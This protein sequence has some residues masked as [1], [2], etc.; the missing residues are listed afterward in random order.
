VLPALLE[1]TKPVAVPPLLEAPEAVVDEVA[2]SPELVIPVPLPDAP[3]LAPALL[4]A[5]A[6]AP[7][8]PLLIVGPGTQPAARIVMAMPT[9][10]TWLSSLG[11]RSDGSSSVRA[12]A[13]A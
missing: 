11:A 1:P 4:A 8:L 6:E 13:P 10:F 5:A 7:V 3:E 2:A 9:H 12:L